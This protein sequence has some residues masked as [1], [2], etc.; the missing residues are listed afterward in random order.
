MESCLQF[1]LNHSLIHHEKYQRILFHNGNKG[2]RLCQHDE[3]AP[4]VLKTG[5]R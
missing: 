1:F 5:G 3:F 4:A 2:Y